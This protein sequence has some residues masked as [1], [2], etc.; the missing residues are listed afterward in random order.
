MLYLDSASL[1]FFFLFPFILTINYF[2]EFSLQNNVL[3]LY[4]KK[5]PNQ[6]IYEHT[7]LII[8]LDSTKIGKNLDFEDKS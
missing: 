7:V 1:F 5:K 4:T 2:L 3:T 8:L 6:P